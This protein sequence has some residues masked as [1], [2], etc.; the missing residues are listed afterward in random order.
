MLTLTL[1]DSPRLTESIKLC[2]Q[3]Q[4]Q[5]MCGHVKGV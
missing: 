4:H 2:L 5:R 1:V 3:E